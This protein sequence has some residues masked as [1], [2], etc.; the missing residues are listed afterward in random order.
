MG[1][2]SDQ[3]ESFEYARRNLLHAKSVGALANARGAYARLSTMARR[4]QWLLRYL[5]GIV[6]RLEGVPN[7]M[8][9]HR[10]EERRRRP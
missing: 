2:P 9:R 5:A 8:A 6:E 3:L 10:D 1:K 4:P 7:E